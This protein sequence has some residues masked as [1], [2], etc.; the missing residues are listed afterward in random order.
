MILQAAMSRGA[1]V[2]LCHNP[3]QEVPC[4]SS[5]LLETEIFIDSTRTTKADIVISQLLRKGVFQ[6]ATAFRL[7]S[8][9]L[10][11]LLYTLG[12]LTRV[13][14]KENRKQRKLFVRQFQKT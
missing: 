12:K 7:Y 14:L 2:S 13:T 4:S 5:H 10:E 9:C 1:V 8:P 3:I 11:G 6:Y